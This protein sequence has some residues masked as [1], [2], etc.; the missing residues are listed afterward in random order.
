MIRVVIGAVAAAIAMFFLGFVFFATPLGNIAVG[1]LDDRGAAEVQAALAEY[2]GDGG[3]QTVAVPGITGEVQQRM[4]IDGP[5]AMIHFNPS[6][7]AVGDTGTMIS[8]F[9]FL[10][11]TALLIGAALYTL[12]AHVRDFRAR[13][14]IAALF[15]VACSAFM[16]LG[17]P[18]WWHQDWVFHIYLFVTD[19]VMFGAAAAIIARWFLP[20][21]I[22]SEDRFGAEES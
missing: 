1:E 19:I 13:F 6:G 10:L 21:E 2:M 17:M 11:I 7:F 22:R 3:T 16:H 18:V 5:T 12:S 20:S 8:G 14:S 4:Y 9:V 15:I